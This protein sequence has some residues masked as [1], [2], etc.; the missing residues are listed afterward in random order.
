MPGFLNTRWRMNSCTG[1][2][3][4]LKALSAG[5]FFLDTVPVAEKTSRIL[6]TVETS[7]FRLAAIALCEHPR[8]CL[9]QTIRQRRS[10]LYGLDLCG[11][12]DAIV[13]FALPLRF[14]FKFCACAAPI[15]TRKTG[16]DSEIY[17]TCN[18][19]LVFHQL[20]VSFYHIIHIEIC[21]IAFGNGHQWCL[22]Q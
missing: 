12:Q 7:T 16:K 3:I 20:S 8:A 1:S 19:F 2:V 17:S 13:E 11:S 10:S 4:F 5:Y 6:R 21:I 18:W 14:E 15:L 22:L 9:C